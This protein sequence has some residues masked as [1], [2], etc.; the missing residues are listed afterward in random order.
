MCHHIL[1]NETVDNGLRIKHTLVCKTRTEHFEWNIQ[2]K[3]QSQVLNKVC[4]LNGAYQLQSV[5]YTGQS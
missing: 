2:C 1:G 3:T 4:R 5:F